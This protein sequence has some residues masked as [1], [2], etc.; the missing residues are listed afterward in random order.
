MLVV[1][2]RQN[3][4]VLFPNLGIS[5]EIVRVKGKT[6]RLGIDAPRDVRAVRG[7]LDVYAEDKR[8]GYS[9]EKS[10]QIFNSDDVQKSLDAANLAIHLAQN[11]LRQGIVENAEVALEHAVECL[12]TLETLLDSTKSKSMSSV[13]EKPTN[14]AYKSKDHLPVAIIVGAES[15]DFGDLTKQLSTSG[16]E[17]LTF[18][19]SFKAI[20]YLAT[21]SQPQIVLTQIAGKIPSKIQLDENAF[22]Q[23]FD[24]AIPGI[25][26]L[27]RALSPMS[28]GEHLLQAWFASERDG[29]FLGSSLAT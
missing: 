23:D 6:V 27:Q 2:R 14:Y 13:R 16:Y 26:G 12:Q 9:K 10:K 19:D 4:K 24:V 11:Q 22:A 21:H 29:E 15:A 17:V 1:S 5:V 18:A 20:E 28:V 25:R 8:S 3:E 7:E